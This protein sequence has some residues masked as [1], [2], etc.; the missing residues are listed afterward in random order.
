MLKAF[1][2]KWFFLFLII[3]SNLII[4]LRTGREFFYFFFWFLASLVFVS[5][6][7][8]ASGYLCL[9]KIYLERKV[10]G[11]IE[12]DDTLKIEAVIKNANLLPIFNFVL[13]DYVSSAVPGERKKKILLEHFKGR[14]SL[15]LKYNCFCPQRGKYK[16]G[17]FSI[18]IFDY[19]GL[20]FLKKTYFVY[21]ELYVYPKTFNIQKLPSLVK[22]IAPWFG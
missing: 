10:T 14:S 2:K 22:G 11:K 19:W 1:L 7:W 3:I 13:Q 20:F 16:I 4:A 17:P 6:L 9:K 15:T 21:S 5:I 8:V 12:E 18:Y